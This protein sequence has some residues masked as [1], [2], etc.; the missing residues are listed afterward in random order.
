[1]LTDLDLTALGVSF[2]FV[3]FTVR[4]SWPSLKI[5]TG[6]YGFLVGRSP[7]SLIPQ[8]SRVTAMYIVFW[9]TAIVVFLIPIINLHNEIQQG[10]WVELSQQVETG[11]LVA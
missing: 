2:F 10:F 9:G 5:V 7:F 8:C 3:L 4:C 6:I 11:T 1:M